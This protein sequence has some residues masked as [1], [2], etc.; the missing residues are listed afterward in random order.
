MANGTT[1]RDFLRHTT[2]AGAGIW[3]LGGGAVQALQMG[4]K[5]RKVSANEKLNVAGIGAGGKGGGDISNAG[6]R[7]NIVAVCDVDKRQAAGIMKNHPKAKFYQDF[8]KMLD[9][10]H[11]EID[12]V[13]VSTP[14]H[15]HAVAAMM[16]MK[17][18]KHVYCQKPLCHDVHEA[19]ALTEAAKKYGVVT[20]MGN[21]GTSEPGLR[22]AV[23]VIWSGAIGKIK[24]VHVWTNRPVWPQ[25]QKR[26]AKTDPVPA[27]LDWDLWLG[28][29]PERPYVD[30]AYHTFNWRGWW[31]FGTGALG[32]MAC[33][34]A[35]MAFMACKLGYPTSVI[36]E[37][38]DDFNDDSYPTWSI[39]RYEFP[40]R[41]DL[42][43]LKWNWYDGGNNKPPK[44]LDEIKRYAQGLKLSDSGSLLV[45]EKGTLFS[46]N[47]YGADFQLLPKKDFEGYKPPTPTLPRL[48]NEKKDGTIEIVGGDEWHN[49]EWT[50]ACKG[51]G[52]TLS[53]FGYAGPLTETVVLGCVAMRFH[54]Q[55]LEWDGPNMKVTN[56]A[57]ANK[58][59]KREYRA[60]WEL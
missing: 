42:P 37:V 3:I 15:Q 36:A 35:N 14:D 55:K 2:Y 13:T 40:A 31:D 22:T 19:R 46:P 25:G 48:K 28:T 39:I 56:I 6:R 57:E 29:A 51:K 16:A 54:G 8:R 38:S 21:Q 58:F 44:A 33:H 9:E 34:T 5:P 17:M 24:E 20:Q 60:G 11:K 1:R 47:D 52:K 7:D 53:N 10:M 12:A 4:A 49:K 43:A 59:L 50:D 45:G 23:E 27:E 30:G 32:D 18:G 26:K 41:G